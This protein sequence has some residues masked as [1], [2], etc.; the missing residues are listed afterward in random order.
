MATRTTRRPTVRRATF[1]HGDLRRALV[2]AALTLVAEGQGE[3][4]TLR[5][6]ARRVGVNHRAVY[7]HFADKRTLLVAVAIEGWRGLLDRIREVLAKQPADAPTHDR[8]L[9][10]G[11][12]YVVHA[13]AHPEHYRVM[14]GARLNLDGRFP[15]L[16][17]VMQEAITMVTAEL[18]RGMARRELPAGRDITLSAMTL[19]AAIHGVTHLVLEQRIVIKP[20][21]LAG[22]VEQLLQP[23]LRGLELD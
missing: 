9:A 8:L 20:T 6:A 21:K 14:F 11:K 22:Y 10:V 5:E 19:W 18:Q 13:L 16:E 4:F 1:H 3:S 15:D 17:A 7:H 23:L 2:A 12:A